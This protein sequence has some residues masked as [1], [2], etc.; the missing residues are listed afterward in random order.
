VAAPA[1]AAE[2]ALA[3]RAA[4]IATIVAARV[5][6]ASWAGSGFARDVDLVRRQ[7]GPLH[8]RR[9]LV[10]SYERESSRLVAMRRLASDPSAPPLE[11][12][13][14]EAAYAIRWLELAADGASLPA[15]ADLA[16]DQGRTAG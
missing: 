5:L 2:H 9:M 8:D 16:R 12:N 11:M 6:P 15:W 14:T 3:A 13:P 1:P 4:E 10:A 7:L